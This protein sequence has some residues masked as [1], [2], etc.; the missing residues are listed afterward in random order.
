MQA[1]QALLSRGLTLAP[2]QYWLFQV[3]GWMAFAALSYFS[4][5]IWYNPGQLTPAFHT[6]LQSVMGIGVSHPLRAVARR[7]WDR[8]AVQRIAYNVIAVVIASLLWTALRLVTFVELTGEIIFA[9]DWGGW[10]FGSVIVFSAWTVSY[11]ALVYYR[12]WTE[13]K[14]K[15]VA[16]EREAMEAR[17]KVREERVKRFEAEKLSQAAELRMLKYQLKPHFLFN[18]LNSVSALVQSERKDDASKMLARIG[19]FL[20]LSLEQDDALVHTLEDEMT[21]IGLYLDIERA[22]FGERLK[23]TFEISDEAAFASVPKLLIQPIIENV[24]K[25]VV[26]RTL[27]Q[28]AITIRARI[29]GSI[30]VLD[31]EDSGADGKEDSAETASLGIGL[32]NVSDR[33]A[34]MYADQQSF[35]MEPT[36]AGGT[37][38]RLIFPKDLNDIGTNA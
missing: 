30:L 24:M 2:N 18:A 20:R 34:S 11:H 14:E 33:L 38:V 31:V 12:Q 10:I 17:E 37:R 1:E 36:E 22:R 35:S 23:T 32:S 3:G 6:F 4:L 8:P 7:A 15:A 29:D 13:Q 16:A 19:D 21:M 27:D 25:H 26:S 5:T 28:V 9:E